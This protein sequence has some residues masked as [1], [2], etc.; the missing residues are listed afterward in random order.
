L[1][2]RLTFDRR[3]GEM[4]EMR[5][6]GGNR[7]KV[8][9]GGFGELATIQIHKRMLL[10]TFCLIKLKLICLAASKPL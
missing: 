2:N 6:M 3:E 10:M 5:E 1:K 8:G 4:K 7:G 9:E